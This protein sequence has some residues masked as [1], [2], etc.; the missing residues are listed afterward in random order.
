MINI[1]VLV[2][3]DES[4]VSKDIQ[5]SLKKL[6]YTVVGAAS[7]GEKAL[8]LVRSEAPDIVL[9]DIMLKGKMNGIEVSEI[10]KKEL[11][12]PVIYLTAYADEATLS[13]AKVTEPYG[14]II[15]PFKEI[16][17]H[18][19]I[20]MAIYKH[21]KHQ[22]LERERDMLFSLVDSKENVDGFIF[23]KSNSRLVKLKTSDIY[24]IE[25]LK[26]YV[27][28]NTNDTRYTIHSTMKEIDKK[29]GKVEF[30]RVHRSFIVRVDKIASIEYPNLNLENEKKVIPIGGMYRDDLVN[31]IRTV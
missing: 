2:V 18:T 24:Y 14:Y 13:K 23:V 3:E 29:L 8:E 25:A 7:T 26:D 15:K 12:I 17:L 11:S 21:R 28:I 22:E 1:N 9:M 31:R 20:E 19:S 5:H 10:I 16:D 30:I 27:V 4:I 6:G